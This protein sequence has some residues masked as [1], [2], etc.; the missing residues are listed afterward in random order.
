MI[1]GDISKI[2]TGI[3]DFKAIREG[4]CL[5]IDKTAFIERF[6]TAPRTPQL[7][8]RPRR[9][10]KSLGLDM[11]RRFLSSEEDS[12]ALFTGFYIESS[13]AWGK[14]NSA[15]VIYLNLKDV[16]IEGYKSGIARK[17]LGQS[18]RYP[19]DRVS[20]QTRRALEWYFDEKGV[21]ADGLSCLADYA[22]EATG[23]KP[24]ILIDEYDAPLEGLA[25]KAGY[26]DALDYMRRF[27]SAGLKDNEN[28]ERA[29]MVG[30]L[31]VQLA[32]MTSGLSNLD[33]HDIFSDGT[34]AEDFGFTES[35]MVDLSRLAGFDLAE[36]REWYN[37][38]KVAGK[39]VYNTFSVL[40]AIQEGKVESY[41][42]ATGN[43]LQ[44]ARMLTPGRMDAVTRMLGG[45]ARQASYERHIS[46]EQLGRGAGDAPFYSFAIQ[47]GYLA[48]EPLAS[49]GQALGEASL[50][51]PNRELNGVWS[52]Y[53]CD[54]F[55]PDDEAYGGFK[56]IFGAYFLEPA[57]F[58]EELEGLLGM[59]ISYQ[60]FASE[61]GDAKRLHTEAVYSAFL[62]GI[63]CLPATIGLA[64]LHPKSEQ[65]K[66]AGIGRVDITFESDAWAYAF[67]LK[68]SET[69]SGL[70]KK[71]AEALAQIDEK[72]YFAAFGQSKKIVKV[73]IAFHQKLCK[74]V[75]AAHN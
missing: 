5:Y 69:D 75:A 37:G 23:A 27:L 61:A 48:A 21:G 52:R 70:D 50:T 16:S 55:F 39:G 59:K 47:A 51:I 57:R 3:S 11:L 29:L 53:I 26:G 71:A 1:T 24:Y 28:V 67:E 44:L 63:L 15:P 74:V 30:T 36:C 32:G 56:N 18:K 13:P 9:M 38:F 6:L 54:L 31:R 45:E 19:A 10:G 43:A 12:S 49:G 64:K 42:T 34:Y 40:S 62:C 20:P 25:G 72:K 14:R 8:C 41:W 2:E 35:E 60:I 22:F 73:G 68:Y 46:L 4:G 17:L 33:V 65:E 58:A 7:I 66:E